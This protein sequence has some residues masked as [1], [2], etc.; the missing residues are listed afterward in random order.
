PGRRTPPGPRMTRKA[1]ETPGRR[2]RH[3]PRRDGGPQ[4]GEALEVVAL[5]H[6]L[7]DD[8]RLA[9]VELRDKVEEH[10]PDGVAVGVPERDD[11]APVLTE[12]TGAPAAAG[13]QA[14]RGDR[15]AE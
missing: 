3:R 11:D 2:G 4:L 1:H 5:V 12:R 6:R 7:D 10:L 13:R 14:Q 15:R 8:P 9:R